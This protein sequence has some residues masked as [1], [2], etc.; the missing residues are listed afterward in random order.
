MTSSGGGYGNSAFA[1]LARFSPFPARRITS[2]GPL[3]AFETTRP[4]DAIA[5][6]YRPFRDVAA[7]GARRV[8]RQTFPGQLFRRTACVLCLAE[9]GGLYFGSLRCRL[10]E[11]NS[12]LSA[13]FVLRRHNR[14]G[15]ICLRLGTAN[16][17][18]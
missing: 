6:L 18:W 9:Y 11:S 1:D 14:R 2:T 16:G 17:S 12:I 8:I 4:G 3:N 5:L 10:L 15:L 13:K 7:G